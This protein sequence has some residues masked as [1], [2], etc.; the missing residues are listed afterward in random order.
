MK[1]DEVPVLINLLAI[2]R[3]D[4]MPDYPMQFMTVGRLSRSNPKELVLKYR[5]TQ[6]DDETGESQNA[7]VT[8]TLTADHVTMQRAG[9]FSNMMSFSKGQRFEGMYTTPYGSM[10]M[11]VTTRDL[12]VRYKG[13]KGSVH[14]KYQ[15][16][17]QGSYASTNEL[18]LEFSEESPQYRKKEGTDS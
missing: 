12:E 6:P 2:A 16:D 17:F 15:V 3:Y 13:G 18:H 1:R 11:A 7:D 10:S 4:R 5:E 8:L 9:E 14:L